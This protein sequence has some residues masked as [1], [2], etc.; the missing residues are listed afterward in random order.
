MSDTV[1]EA[2]ARGRREVL[3]QVAATYCAEGTLGNRTCGAPYVEKGKTKYR[4]KCL[5]HKRE[6][7]VSHT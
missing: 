4:E 5:P 1:E 2:Y 6:C 3:E 7:A